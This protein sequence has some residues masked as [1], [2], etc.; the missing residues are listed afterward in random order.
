MTC[1]HASNVVC[2]V[3]PQEED[4]EKEEEEVE[5]ETKEVDVSEED[6]E[7]TEQEEDSPRDLPVPTVPSRPR[8]VTKPSTTPRTT[9]RRTTKHTTARP[10]PVPFTPKAETPLPD[11]DYNDISHM[12][13]PKYVPSDTL[14]RTNTHTQNTHTRISEE[15][16]EEV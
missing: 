7:E 10:R 13:H 2:N 16:H 11:L 3:Q 12:Q 8:P 6:E 5:E 1:D 9:T 4:I 14:R 15:S